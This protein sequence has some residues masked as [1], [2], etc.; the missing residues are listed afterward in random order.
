MISPGFDIILMVL[1]PLV[2][3]FVA[4]IGLSVLDEQKRSAGKTLQLIGIFA[5]FLWLIYVEYILLS[6]YFTTIVMLLLYST[7]AT[8]YLFANPLILFFFTVFVLGSLFYIEYEYHFIGWLLSYAH[9]VYETRK[10][11]KYRR[12]RYVEFRNEV[13]EWG[14]AQ[15]FEKRAK[16]VVK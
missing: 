1:I 2:I 4:V 15:A 7:V 16:E 3:L 14:I 13:K 9:Y 10:E 11:I 5:V 8:L 12:L 6:L